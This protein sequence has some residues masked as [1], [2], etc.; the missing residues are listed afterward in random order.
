MEM[1]TRNPPIYFRRNLENLVYVAR[2][3]GVQPVLSTFAH[4]DCGKGDAALES[5][6]I[7]RGIAEH[8]EVVREIGKALDVPVLDLAAALPDDPR[9][10]VGA[11]HFSAE[12]NG[13]RALLVA[14]FLVREG[15]VPR[16]GRGGEGRTGA[17]AD[18]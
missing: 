2:G 13:R 11:V 14:D 5:P 8:I 3:N 7:V 9:Y 4:C 10:F 1:L 15:L 12:G 17:D 18:G 6:E 16:S